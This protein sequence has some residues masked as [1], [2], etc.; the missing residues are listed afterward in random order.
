MLELIGVIVSAA[1]TVACAILAYAS[2]KQSRI[3]KEDRARVEKRAQRRLKESRLSLE[4][5]NANCVL[6]V[7]TALAVKRGH[8][9]G[10]LDDGLAQVEAA[11]RKY[12]DFLK[13]V[14][15]E[16]VVGDGT[17]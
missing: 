14:A 3:M 8:A 16:D 17:I 15:I 7:G 9:N 12:M 13:E 4:L 10:E 2:N 5:M 1:A 6:T 11:R